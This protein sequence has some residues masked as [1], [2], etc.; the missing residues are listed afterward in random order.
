LRQRFPGTTGARIYVDDDQLEGGCG[1]IGRASLGGPQ[2]EVRYLGAGK[3]VG[4]TVVDRH[5]LF[6][7]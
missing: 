6:W 5:G 3:V 7:R 1:K 2:R 4:R